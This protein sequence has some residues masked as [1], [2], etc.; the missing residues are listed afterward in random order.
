MESVGNDLCVLLSLCVH[1]YRDAGTGVATC[2]CVHVCVRMSFH[3]DL[4]RVV[5]VDS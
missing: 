5:H 2:S 4:C 3:I 1:V